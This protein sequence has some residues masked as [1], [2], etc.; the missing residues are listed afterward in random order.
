M[1]DKRE[2]Y[3]FLISRRKYEL[4]LKKLPVSELCIKTSSDFNSLLEANNSM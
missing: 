4:E 1:L 2:K 3:S